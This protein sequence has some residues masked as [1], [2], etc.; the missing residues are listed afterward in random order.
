[1]P[2][3]KNSSLKDPEL[4][5]K[6]RDDGASKEK[7]AR[8]SNAAASRGRSAVGRKGGKSGDY[9]DWTVEKLRKRAAEIGI[10]GR[11]SM[12]KGELV[13]ALRNH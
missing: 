11:S 8:I 3:R 2:G 5:E 10:E 7:A 6:L 4:Y 9:D 13:K 12:R 1:M